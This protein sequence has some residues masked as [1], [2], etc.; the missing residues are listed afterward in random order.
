MRRYT[1]LVAIL[2][3]A[4]T[5]VGVIPPAHAGARKRRIAPNRHHTWN[6]ATETGYDS[7]SD[8]VVASGPSP[9]R[10]LR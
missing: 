9:S 1:W 10:S 6:V 4:A 3:R 8:F 5:A 7:R 2:L